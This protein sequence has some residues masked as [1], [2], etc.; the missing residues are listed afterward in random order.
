MD[1][2]RHGGLLLVREGQCRRSWRSTRSTS[3]P[4]RAPASPRSPASRWCRRRCRPAAT[5]SPTRRSRASSRSGRSPAGPS[6]VIIAAGRARRSARRQWTPD[7]T[8]D[9]AGR[10]RAHQQPLP[11]GLQQAARDRHRHARP[12]RS[13]PVAE[14][15]RQISDREEGAAVLSPDGKHGRLHHG[16]GAARDAGQPR[17]LAGRP[18]VAITTEVAD[19]PSWAATRKT[20]L[21]K[22]ADKLRIDP[23]PTAPARRTCR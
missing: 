2:G 21:Y 5:A 12:A 14:A 4:R 7:G 17:R 23:A 10:Q 20:I 18:A 15:P 22:S 1:A 11:R 19:L 13:M 8:Q 16:L 3:R 9:H 6:A